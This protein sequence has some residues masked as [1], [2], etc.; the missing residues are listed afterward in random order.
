M[1]SYTSWGEFLGKLEDNNPCAKQSAV[2]GRDFVEYKDCEEYQK[3]LSG[4]DLLIHGHT[5]VKAPL[6]VGNRLHIDTGLVYGKHLTIYEMDSEEVFTF[7]LID[8]VEEKIV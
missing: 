7:K 1:E 6:K 3:P 2:W 8:K 5:P 4:V